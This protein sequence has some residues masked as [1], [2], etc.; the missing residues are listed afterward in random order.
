MYNK[1]LIISF[2]II[3]VLFINSINSISKGMNFNN[4]LK[5]YFKIL[6]LII[7]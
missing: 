2:L 3:S 1:F 7:Y 4:I 5:Y 6:L